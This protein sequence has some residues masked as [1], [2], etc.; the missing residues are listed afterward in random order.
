[1]AREPAPPP[2]RTPLLDRGPRLT[3]DIKI[4]SRH[5]PA[6]GPRGRPPAHPAAR[7]RAA[8]NTHNLSGGRGGTGWLLAPIADASTHPVTHPPRLTRDLRSCR[9]EQRCWVPLPHDAGR[10]GAGP[11]EPSQASHQRKRVRSR[12]AGTAV[13][14]RRPCR[15]VDPARGRADVLPAAPALR[16]GGA[17]DDRAVRAQPSAP[18]AAG[19][20]T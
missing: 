14:T 18:P 19:G 11:T 1:M 8:A 16:R 2:E 10:A 17:A 15:S 7:R 3:G 9:S 13:P 20:P 4:A 12:P 5:T 6:L